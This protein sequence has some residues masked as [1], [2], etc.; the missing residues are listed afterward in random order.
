MTVRAKVMIGVVLAAALGLPAASGAQDDKDAP[1]AGPAAVDAV[2]RDAARVTAD[3]WLGKGSAAYWFE[4]GPTPAL[5]AQTPAATATHEEDDKDHHLVVSRTL[6]GLQAGTTYYVRLVAT[7]VGS[8][9]GEPASFTTAAAPASPPPPSETAPE[10]VAAPAEEAAP[11]APALGATVAVVADEGSVRVRLPGSDR[12]I[13]LPQAATVPTE[14]VIDARSGAVALT[15]ALPGGAVQTGHFGGARFKVRQAADGRTDL[16]LRG[17]DF[18]RC[19]ARAVSA[20][21]AGKK[22]HAVRRIWGRDRGGHFRTHG[23][24][25]VTTVRGTAWSV[26]D[27]C[28]GTVT[29]VTEGAVD[30]RLRHTGRVVRL[31][32]GER[33]VARHRR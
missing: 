22:P 9:T 2:T 19:D 33:L 1:S 7:G 6:T 27:R 15:A 4:Y 11:V 17:G 21:A 5:G 13:E 12:F 24:D 23:R 26:A 16:H 14:S 25:S 30:V 3:L 28:D 20:L 29:R 18:A 31:R 10:P 32:A 8:D